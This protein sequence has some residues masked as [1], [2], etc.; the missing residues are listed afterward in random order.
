MSESPKKRTFNAKRPEKTVRSGVKS[1]GGYRKK[2]SQM[3]DEE[4]GNR[5]RRFK[6]KEQDGKPRRAAA[7]AGGRSFR[8]SP[9]V[10]QDEE[11]GNKPRRFKSE[12]RDGKP[13]RAAAA[14]GRSFRKEPVASQDGERGNRPR[15]FKSEERDGKPRR[16]AAAGGRSFRK[17]PVVSQDEERGNRPRRFKSEERD[18]Q[19]RRA[20]AAGRRPFRKSPVA[21]QDERPKRRGR[22]ITAESPILSEIVAR[23]EREGRQTPK[24]QKVLSLKVE[25]QYGPV[26]LNKY[27][28]NAG[29]CSRRDADMLIATGAITVNGKAVTELGIKVLSVD[30]V[31]YG[32]KVLQREKPVYLLLNKPKDYITTTDDDRDRPHVIQLVQNACSERIY[33]VG[34]LDRDTTGLL[35]FTNDGEMTKKLTHPSHLVRKM[36]HVGLNKNLTNSD[37]Q[38]IKEGLKLNDGLIKP[39]ELDYVRDSKRELG[40]TI[41][42][43][44]NRIVRRIFESLGYEIEK[45]DRV[46][47]AGLTKKDLPRG[48]WRFLTRAEINI[49]KMSINKQVNP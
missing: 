10:S 46:V 45:L 8:K 1:A 47:F 38:A 34:R 20:A 17:S 22:D 35:L 25:E 49:L 9:V 2:G 26:R 33:P 13:R 19:P 39:D 32:D 40:I 36:Y 15:R 16:A 29:I 37:F 12:E 4:Q 28:A 27:I 31:R 44:R 18:G 7:A 23:R 21:S 11:R 41:H 14:G 42:S 3:R 30:E 5:P 24:R 43:G 48:H 6:S